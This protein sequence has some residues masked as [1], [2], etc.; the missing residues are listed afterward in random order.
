[1]KLRGF[2]VVELLIVITVIGILIPTTIF[3]IRGLN[4][5]AADRERESDATSIARRLELNYT[6]KSFGG[7]PNYPGT[8]SLSASNKEEI[9]GGSSKDIL[10]APGGANFS[11]IA[12][13]PG[14]TPAPT[15]TTYIY[16]PMRYDNSSGVKDF[17]L[18]TTS[19]ACTKFFLYYLKKSDNSIAV[20]K[21]QRQQ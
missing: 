3:T 14:V 18:C 20:I 16:Q 13:T 2:T 4:V 1:M 8:N 7:T 10:K 11:I 12:A 15:E 5:T 9:F 21:S 6:N 19:N 17:V